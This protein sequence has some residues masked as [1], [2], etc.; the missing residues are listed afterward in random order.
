MWIRGSCQWVN[1]PPLKGG[2]CSWPPP[3]GGRHAT[4]EEQLSTVWPVDNGPGS[5]VQSRDVVCWPSVAA[6]LT[7]ERTPLGTVAARDVAANGARLAG[8]G[9][10]N[11][12][13]GHTITACL[14]PNEGPELEETPV[15]QSC[16]LSAS[17]RYPRANAR[18]ILKGNRSLGAF[19]LLHELLGDAV[20]HVLLEASLA[21]GDLA[22][23]ATGCPRPLALKVPAAMG[24][25]A[26]TPLYVLAREGLA[27]AVNRDVDD[28]QVDPEHVGRGDGG[29]LGNVACRDDVEIAPLHLEIDLALPMGEE[30]P[31]VFA[32]DERN[33]DA[34]VNRPDGDHIVG[35]HPEDAVVEGLCGVQPKAV[36]PLLVPLVARRD[37]GDTLDDDLGG[38][39][40]RLP[41]VLVHSPMD[42][43]AFED[44]VLPGVCADLVAGGVSRP[45][46]LQQGRLLLQGR[47]ELDGGYQLHVTHV[48]MGRCELQPFCPKEDAHSSP[49][50]KGWGILREI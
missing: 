9:G 15:V 35:A 47:Q 40:A 29:G 22:E 48:T 14:V 12:E 24:V 5:D 36:V 10:I 42:I 18:E 13:H 3:C 21:P 44:A 16:S 27:I 26:A 34:T 1:Y 50:L 49:P 31:L 45:Q 2:A 11:V 39:P 41:D 20:V 43:E 7:A 28:A 32:A 37:L 25:A 6:D 38:E 33:L 30:L 4:L 17:G 19:R 23:L 46:R 8:V